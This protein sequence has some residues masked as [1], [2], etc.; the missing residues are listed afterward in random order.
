MHSGK[1]E[2]R[3]EGRRR[4]ANLLRGNGEGGG[5]REAGQVRLGEGERGRGEVWGSGPGLCALACV[6]SH[7]HPCDRVPHRGCECV[8]LLPYPSPG[9]CRLKGRCWR[10]GGS[11][12]RPGF[13]AGR[14]PRSPRGCPDPTYAR[15]HARNRAGHW[16]MARHQTQVR[17]HK[18]M[19]ATEDPFSLP[20]SSGVWM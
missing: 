9:K 1:G 19:H 13:M 8:S 2:G 15:L 14:E 6:Y 12:A 17:M 7:V 5:D 3:G 18:V 16:L 11:L 4:E 20:P 10:S